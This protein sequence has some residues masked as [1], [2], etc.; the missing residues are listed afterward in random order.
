MKATVWATL[1]VALVSVQAVLLPH[2]TVWGVMPDLGLIVVCLVGLFGGELEG[3]LLG[4][5]LGWIMSLFS[6]TDLATSM[7]TKGAVGYVAGLAGR[8]VVYLAPAVLL[9]GILVASCASGLLTAALLN[10]SDQQD[11][12]WAVRTVVVPQA[13]IDAMAGG[14][15][16]WLVWSRLNIQRWVSE[17]RT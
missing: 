10:L 17:Y 13:I 2:T 6:A 3:L 5:A 14:A 7:I 15:L 11:W 1:I 9:L 8:H 16:Y 12:W 4:L